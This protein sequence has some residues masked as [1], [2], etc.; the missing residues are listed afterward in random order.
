MFAT[1]L[2][3]TWAFDCPMLPTDECGSETE[4]RTWVNTHEQLCWGPL[5][6][7]MDRGQ[8]PVHYSHPPLTCASRISSDIF[9]FDS[10]LNILFFFCL[11]IFHFLREDLELC[12]KAQRGPVTREQGALE[13]VS[14]SRSAA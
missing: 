7:N 13:R 2:G 8:C 10:F 1:A 9:P 6:Q 11:I 12:P 3:R 14:G 5:I 4:A